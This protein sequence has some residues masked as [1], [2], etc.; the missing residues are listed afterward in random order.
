MGV[1]CVCIGAGISLYDML[2][3]MVSASVVLVSISVVCTVWP[4]ACVSARFIYCW[5]LCGSIRVSYFEFATMYM[6][7][8]YFLGWVPAVV[9]VCE[10]V[11]IFGM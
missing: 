9:W 6:F 5:M 3:S 10:S 11:A 7:R 1:W 2:L 4:Y 8:L